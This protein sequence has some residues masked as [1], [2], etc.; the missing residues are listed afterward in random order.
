MGSEVLSVGDV[1]VATLPEQVP[2]GREQKGYRPVIV[3]GVPEALG[4]SRY[5][6]LLVI[7]LTTNREQSWAIE[8][9]AL[10]PVLAEGEGALPTSSIAL[11]DQV[12]SLDKSRVNRYIGTLTSHQYR[13]ILSG[14]SKMMNFSD[15]G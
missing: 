7:P 13:P 14:L 10:Y 3:V 5:P 6:M 9:P 4:T 2:P 15:L 12:R 1:I 8:C 11:L